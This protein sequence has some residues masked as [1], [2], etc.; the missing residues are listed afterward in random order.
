MHEGILVYWQTGSCTGKS[1]LHS[2]CA[3]FSHNN[4]EQVGY[5]KSDH[6]HRTETSLTNTH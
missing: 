5:M 1:G 3:C 2:Q 4:K 6:T